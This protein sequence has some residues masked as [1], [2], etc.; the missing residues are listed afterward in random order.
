MKPRKS[1]APLSTHKRIQAE[2]KAIMRSKSELTLSRLQVE[3]AK[4]LGTPIRAD[5]LALNLLGMRG[6]VIDCESRTVWKL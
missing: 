6:L 1:T 3:L 4:R 5:Y 2:V